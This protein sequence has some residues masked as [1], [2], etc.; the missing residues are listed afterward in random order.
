MTKFAKT[1]TNKR[2]F[3][4]EVV[5]LKF[6]RC[7]GLML[8]FVVLATSA[9]SQLR[10]YPLPKKSDNVVSKSKSKNSTSRTKELT[11]RSLPFWDDFSW[12]Q[13]DLLTDTLSNYP[14]D[15]L[16]VNNYSVWINN[17]LGLNPPSINVA[18]FNGLDSTQNPYADQILA[19]GFRDTLTSQP[20]KMDEVADGDRNSVYLSFFYQWAGNGE[21]P[22]END[23]LQ[24]DFKNDQGI[25]E[26]AA[27]IQ[28]LPTLEDNVF[29]DTLIKV[30][31]ERFFHQDFQ[32]RFKNYGRLSGPY[33]TWHLDYI[34]LNKNRSP[35]DRYLPDRTIISTLT[36][37]FSGYRSIPYHHFL[38]NKTVSQPS[39]DVF[40]VQ[41]DT[42]TLSYSTQGTFINYKDGMASLPY[43]IDTLGGAGTSPIDGATGII[44]QRE[45]KTVTLEHVPDPNDGSQFNQDAD[46]VAVSLKVQLFTGD[47]FNPKTGQFA[48]DYDPAKLQ[49]LDF[50][51]ND[52]LRANYLLGNFYAYDDGYAEYTVG[53]T[54]FG[55]RAACQF[56]MLTT[57]PDTL[58]GFDIYYPDYGVPGNLTIDFT[59]YDDMNGLPGTAIYTL[60]SYTIHKMGLNKFA[61]IRFG[62]Q[63]LV[64]GKFYIGWKAP[65]GGTFKVG[66]DTN[67][68]SG[69]KL[70]VNTNGTWEQSTD[71]FGSVMIRPVFGG[72]DIVTGIPDENLQSQIFPN[73]NEGEFFVPT[74][75]HVID[76][77]SVTGQ[78]ISF[79]THDQGEMQ[80]IHL[81][82]ASPGL[83]ILRLQTSSK[84]FSSKIV[85][86]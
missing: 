35:T 52:T 39:F 58:V 38:V 15:S 6:G 79:S 74:N 37:L 34:Y 75:F 49:P 27:T 36:N 50:R 68:D 4:A 77:V 67:N 28:T 59:V 21:P 47:T 43:I 85:V 80:R 24:V 73:P 20:I 26:T 48:N 33:D 1:D 65:V 25:W 44:Y 40:N 54:A 61:K 19:N 66:L 64:E 70:F 81:G 86:K 11:P 18:T 76:I 31:G 53:L 22:D 29:Y 57:E 46:S 84:V 78:Q 10:V 69:T 72:G 71:I 83:Y 82:P 23:Y 9:F 41:N 5:E 3:R 14:L 56:E 63:F 42:S 62:E 8:V 13:V 51:S 12:T 60:P 16:W 30:D 32:F 2:R 55:N 17:G 7:Y 45:R